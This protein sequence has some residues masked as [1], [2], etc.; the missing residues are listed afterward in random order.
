MGNMKFF[1]D[2]IENKLLNLHTAYLAKVLS[3]SNGKARIQPLNM[4]KSYGN[5]AQKQSPLSDVPVINSARNKLSSKTITYMNENNEPVS[6]QIAQL[7][8]LSVGDI[9]I[10]VCAERDISGAKRGEITTPQIGHHNMS[11]SIIVGI[12]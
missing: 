9:V 6:T 7:S 2:M 12:L 3:Y 8:R 11:D 5:S 10:C 1:D 4:I